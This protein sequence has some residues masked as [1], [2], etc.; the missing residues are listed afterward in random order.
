MVGIE[1]L[2]I[3]MAR[4]Y[5]Q[6][7]SMRGILHLKQD[8]FRGSKYSALHDMGGDAEATHHEVEMYIN[9]DVGRITML[10][11]S[12]IGSE[13][14]MR[15]KMHGTIGISIYVGF[16]DIFLTMTCNPNWKEIKDSLL[17]GQKLYDRPD[18]CNRFFCLKHKNLIKYLKSGKP[19]GTVA[20]Y[21]SVIEFQKRGSVHGN[22]I[23]TLSRDAKQRFENPEKVDKVI[24]AEIRPRMIPVCGKWY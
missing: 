22:I 17:P 6:C 1:L 11:Q 4:K 5:I 16:P 9:A 10:L 14:N 3:T 8:N 19:F 24:F 23:S 7:G 18:L 15:I 12:H 20:D 2:K 21:A 13:R